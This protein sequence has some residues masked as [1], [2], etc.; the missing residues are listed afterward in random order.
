M[1]S[2]RDALDV[3]YVLWGERL[4]VDGYARLDTHLLSAGLPPDEGPEAQ[5]RLDAMLAN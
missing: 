5:A 4:G 2:L 1:H 3:A